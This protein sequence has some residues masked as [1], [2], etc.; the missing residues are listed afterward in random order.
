MPGCANPGIFGGRAGANR[1]GAQGKRVSRVPNRANRAGAQG[2]WSPGERI[3]ANRASVGLKCR[4]NGTKRKTVT[5]SQNKKQKV[6]SNHMD[7]TF[8]FLIR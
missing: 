2:K 8:Y 4:S 5:G 3:G 6:L 7:G 1:A